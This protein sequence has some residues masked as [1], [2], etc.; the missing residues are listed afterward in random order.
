MVGGF[1][2]FLIALLVAIPALPIIPAPLGE[3][4][5]VGRVCLGGCW[6]LTGTNSPGDGLISDLFFMFA[7]LYEPVPVLTLAVGVAVWTYLV[8]RLPDAETETLGWAGRS[9]PGPMPLAL[10]GCRF[11]TCVSAAATTEIAG[12]WNRHV[13]IPIITI[14]AQATAVLWPDP[15]EAARSPGT[16]G[17]PTM[18]NRHRP[19][20]FPSGHAADWYLAANRRVSRHLRLVGVSAKRPQAW[21]GSWALGEPSA[22]ES[23]RNGDRR[24]PS[25]VLGGVEHSERAHRRA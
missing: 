3:S 16:R 22:A 2:T 21:I 6:A 17:L 18:R 19:P 11:R 9:F 4:V 14:V 7:P 5:G 8:R 20:R 10:R 1:L 24:P 15:G 23:P 25:A 12:C 13:I